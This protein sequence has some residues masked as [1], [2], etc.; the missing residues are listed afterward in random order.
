MGSPPPDAGVVDENIEL[1]VP[2]AKGRDSIRDL[3]LIRDIC[4][5]HE[6][7]ATSRPD[8]VSRLF[9]LRRRARGD[10]HEV[11]GL[12]ERDGNRAA[13]ATAGAGNQNGQRCHRSPGEKV[14][15][16]SIA[17]VKDLDP[18]R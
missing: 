9:E 8:G 11:A 16:G 5:E 4:N 1:H 14:L 3:R 13:D 15:S 17:Q 12:G 18:A 2:G 7:F 10:A 6:G